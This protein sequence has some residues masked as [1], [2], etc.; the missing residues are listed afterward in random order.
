MMKETRTLLIMSLLAMTGY[1]VFNHKLM[2]IAAVIFVL[3][4]LSSGKIRKLASTLIYK[5]AKL[6]NHLFIV[7]LLT[8]VYV[9][10]LTPVAG[11]QRFFFQNPILIKK[12]ESESYFYR[13]NHIYTS[14]DFENPW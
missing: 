2:L 8:I 7:V 1:L 11:L 10:I 14:K 13:R 3:I 9:F 12:G 4:G 6:I 5:M